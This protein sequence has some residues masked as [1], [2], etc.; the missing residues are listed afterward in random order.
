MRERVDHIPVVPPE[1]EACWAALNE[2]TL[3]EFETFRANDWDAYE[4]I[5]ENAIYARHSVSPGCG[6]VKTEDRP[7]ADAWVVKAELD[8]RSASTSYQQ[9]KSFAMSIDPQGGGSSGAV[10]HE[11]VTESLGFSSR[12]FFHI[13]RNGSGESKV[14]VKAFP[15]Q[16]TVQACSSCQIGYD[17]WQEV[18]AEREAN[19]ARNYLALIE[20][21][22]REGAF[23]PVADEEADLPQQG[24]SV[25]QAPGAA[26]LCAPG[27]SIACAGPGG[28]QGFQVCANDGG[29][30]EPCKCGGP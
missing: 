25:S 10:E 19:L 1:A 6:I 30:F 26:P 29:R 11:T 28:C 3:A 7:G 8:E 24:S 15:V 2:T 23:K 16:G 12:L 27:Q 5:D 4:D 17:F 21:L 13:W 9:L 14:L 18:T 20:E 22:G